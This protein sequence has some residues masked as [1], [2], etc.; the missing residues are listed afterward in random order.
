MSVRRW[1][2]TLL[3][4]L[5]QHNLTEFVWASL[6]TQMMCCDSLRLLSERAST[7]SLIPIDT[8]N[9]HPFPV[10]PFILSLSSPSIY[11][12]TFPF[13]TSTLTN[14]PRVLL[15]SLPLHL[16]RYIL[17]TLLFSTSPLQ[18]YHFFLYQVFPFILSLTFPI[19]I[20]PPL[21]LIDLVNAAASEQ[22]W[23]SKCLLDT[24]EA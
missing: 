10:F 12:E 21:I 5:Y 8:L 14:F 11:L 17:Q 20:S 9:F 16:Q 24:N 23:Y 15:S 4:Y 19:T 6:V 7:F 2:D 1:K 3:L 18:M 13:S 22:K